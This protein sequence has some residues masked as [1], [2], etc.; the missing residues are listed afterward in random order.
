MA[1]QRKKQ[2]ALLIDTSTG[3]GRNIIRGIDRYAREVGNWDLSLQPYAQTDYI[4][5]PVRWSGDG[6][7]ARVAGQKMADELMHSGLPVV[8]VSNLPLAPETTFPKVIADFVNAGRLAAEH[9]VE[10]GFRKFAYCATANAPNSSFCLQQGYSGFLREKGFPCE[11][12]E[13][14]LKRMTPERRQ[15]FVLEWIR[16]QDR[17]LAIL[18]WSID[19]P[20]EIIGACYAGNINI[21]EEVAILSSASAS[22]LI[23]KV[24]NPA[25]SCVVAPETSIGYAAAKMLGKLMTRKTRTKNSPTVLIQPSHVEVRGSSD[26]LQI[27]DLSL[28]KAIR[29]MNEHSTG[30]ICVDEVASHVGLSRRSLEQKMQRIMKRSPAE[31]IRQ[32]RLNY[33]RQLLRTTMLSVPD[34]AERSGFG[35]VEHFI[36]FFRKAVG[37]TPLQYAKNNRNP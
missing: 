2:V 32:I 33:A 27:G 8:N 17:P 21:P 5:L 1:R 15:D 26:V 37:V 31:E 20:H 19:A 18:A 11:F 29:F 7:I 25:V 28:V 36:T 9:F 22:E 23:L 24:M 35:T 3:W 4:P 10:R 16:R 13:I 30:R 6:V 12:M 34:V 14:P